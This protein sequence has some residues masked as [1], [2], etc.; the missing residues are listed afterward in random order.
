MH[1]DLTAGTVTYLSH[2]FKQDKII[3]IE[4]VTAS[5]GDDVIIGTSGA[6]IIKAG[7]GRNVVEGGGGNDTIYRRWSMADWERWRSRV[8]FGWSWQRHHLFE[9][10]T[11]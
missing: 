6:N 10:S 7:D 5:S 3:S 8:S 1:I 4:N 2:G 9:G 11:I